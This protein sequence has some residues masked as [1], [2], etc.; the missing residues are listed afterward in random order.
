LFL[1]RR[2]SIS[3]YADAGFIGRVISYLGRFHGAVVRFPYRRGLLM[4]L[5][6]IGGTQ[7]SVIVIVYLLFHA[8]D[9]PLALVQHL[10]FYPLIGALMIVPVT[11]G[12]FGVREG[13][14][15]WFY[16]LVGV[17]ADVAVAVSVAT[18]VVVTVVPALAGG[19][20]LLWSS[21][22]GADERVPS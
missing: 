10:L 3:G 22:T 11:V 15:V 17:S 19:V 21:M 7:L 5:V 9:H 20:L 6:F 2:L 13:A 12:G 8:M 18:Y 1:S 14:F 4:T 16:S